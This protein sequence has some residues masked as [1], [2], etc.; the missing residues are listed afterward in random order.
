M[1]AYGY[2]RVSTEEQTEGVSLDSQMAKITA[3]ADVHDHVLLDVL[4]D[5]GVSGKGIDNR[6]GLLGTIDRVCKSGGLL[7]VYSISRLSRSTRDIIDI[8]ERLDQHGAQIASITE[9]IDTTSASGRMFFK[10]L[11]VLAEFERE[12][13]VERT[14]AALFRK[15]QRNEVVGNIPYGFR[16]DGNNLVIDPHE[17]GGLRLILAQ[18]DAGTS[19]AGIARMLDDASYCPRSGPLWDRGVVRRICRFHRTA[20]GQLLRE[21]HA[22]SADIPSSVD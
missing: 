2:C 3:Y 17:V 13:I 5:D 16:R 21:K 19:Y 11:A 9:N 6:P 14:T 10:I 1:K 8:A 12:M 22:I 4:S 7:I 18:M 20:N 15:R